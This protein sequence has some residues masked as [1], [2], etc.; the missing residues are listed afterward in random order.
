[1]RWEELPAWQEEAVVLSSWRR[2]FKD[3]AMTP[4]LS[5]LCPRLNPSS[6]FVRRNPTEGQR[7]VRGQDTRFSKVNLSD[8]MSDSKLSKSIR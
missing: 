4:G 2:C 7:D 8:K 6:A 1:M 3:V 5:H